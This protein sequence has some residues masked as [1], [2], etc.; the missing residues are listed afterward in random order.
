MH[1]PSFYIPQ[2]HFDHLAHRLEGHALFKFTSKSQLGS[3]KK[4][5]FGH[6]LS[7]ED[8]LLIVRTHQLLDLK[9]P[10]ANQELLAELN[11]GMN[12]MCYYL[13]STKKPKD[14]RA[15]AIYP[16]NITRKNFTHIYSENS[17]ALAEM[18]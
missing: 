16:V 8:T 11:P 9:I 2:L 14:I 3:V 6:I 17:A 5:T 15:L 13:A 4:L 7:I 1:A 12:V 18:D 10:M